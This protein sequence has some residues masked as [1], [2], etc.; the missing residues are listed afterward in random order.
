MDKYPVIAKIQQFYLDRS[1]LGN[2]LAIQF[3]G[4]HYR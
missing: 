4:G 3:E 1:E 2:N